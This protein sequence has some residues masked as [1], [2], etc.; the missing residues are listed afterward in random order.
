MAKDT[1]VAGI[2]SEIK[3]KF[4]PKSLKVLKQFRKDIT[5]LKKD[6]QS[7]NKLKV[8]PKV[9]MSGAKEARSM[10]V[11]NKAT[12]AAINLEQRLA[13]VKRKRRAFE[14]KLSAAGVT[15]GEL[16]RSRSAFN[17]VS[18]SFS[19]GKKSSGEFNNWLETQYDKLIPK[20]KRLKA[21]E[22][23]I[24]REKREQQRAMK[25]LSAY[26][27]RVNTQAKM[28]STTSKKTGMTFKQMRGSMVGMI[29]AY[30]AFSALGNI[31]KTGQDFENA[32]IMME[33]AL[34]ENA[35]PAMAFLVQQS[36]R[37]GIDAAESAKG[38]ARYALAAR[39]LGFSLG[40][41]KE[42]FLG[43]AEAATVF[44]LSQDQITGTIRAL[45][46]MASKGK[47]MSEEL[48]L[49]LGDRMPAVMQIAAKSVNMTTDQFL[50]A[51]EEGKISAEEFLPAFSSAMRDLAAPGLDKAFKSVSFAQKEN[52]C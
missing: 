6:L 22:K 30:T 15:G 32:G 46:Q 18:G 25:A 19:K 47:I 37:L 4:D 35:A 5:G 26:F 48:K 17:K 42:Q 38:F 13:M 33:T 21:E 23:R 52:D 49:Q 2:Y 44:G 9:Q 28:L 7:L 16:G 27:G 40:D 3:Y 14:G 36:R 12:K 51:M 45:E 31:N 34:G 41:I 20:A 24:T 11:R 50:K 8:S 10:Q 39:E 29:Q 1:R 43:V